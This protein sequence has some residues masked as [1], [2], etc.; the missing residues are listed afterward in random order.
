MGT[1][2]ND[3]PTP[4]AGQRPPVNLHQAIDLLTRNQAFP[5]FAPGH[6]QDFVTDLIQTYPHL[7]LARLV[8]TR[9]EYISKVLQSYRGEV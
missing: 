9:S 2:R 4:A 7:V 1:V 3:T 6:L 8:N 5:D